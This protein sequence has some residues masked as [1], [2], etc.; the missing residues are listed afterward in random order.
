LRIFLAITI[1]PEI[2]ASL[3]RAVSRLRES[4]AAVRW[5]RPD[6]IHQTIKFLG[7]TPEDRLEGLIGS[8]TS[9]CE[10]MVPFQMSVSGLGAFPEIR[11]PRVVWAGVQEPSGTLLRLWKETEETTRM[12]GWQREKRG[13]SPHITLGRVKGTI[14]LGRLN[15]AVR[16]L[17]DEHWGDQE[18]GSMVLYQSRLK[19]GGAEYEVVCVFPFGKELT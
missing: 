18:V 13:F 17:E 4:R 7:E 15:E 12:L 8:V 10:G 2:R 1:N 5:V 16:S 14:N 6:A 9:L 11:R 19:P 3:E